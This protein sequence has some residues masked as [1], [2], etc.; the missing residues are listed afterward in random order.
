MQD[1]ISIFK[2]LTVLFNNLFHIYFTYAMWIVFKVLMKKKASPLCQ[3]LNK[4]NHKL[5][6]KSFTKKKER[7]SY[8]YGH[9]IITKT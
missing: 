4:I 7:N 8:V 3:W 5:P 1:L 9:R 6:R 2:Y